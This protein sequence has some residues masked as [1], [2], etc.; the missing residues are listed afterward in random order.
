MTALQVMLELLPP[1]RWDSQ[2]WICPGHVS[3]MDAVGRVGSR[4]HYLTLVVIL[5]LAQL[6]HLMKSV[7]E[8]SVLCFLLDVVPGAWDCV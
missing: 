3:C 1:S 4:W 5:A 8:T 6:H 2:W 7:Y